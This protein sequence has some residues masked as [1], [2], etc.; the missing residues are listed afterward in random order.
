MRG[1]SVISFLVVV[2]AIAWLILR[3]DVPGVAGAEPD[4]DL[5]VAEAAAGEIRDLEEVVADALDNARRTRR[6][7]DELSAAAE[8]AERAATEIGALSVDNEAAGVTQVAARL[9]AED[10]E[11]AAL[12][13][14]RYADT[15]L[16]RMDAAAEAAEDAEAIA[17]VAIEVEETR[18]AAREAAAAAHAAQAGLAGRAPDGAL[19]GEVAGD[20]YDGEIVI[21]DGR[22]DQGADD[23]RQRLDAIFPDDV[24]DEEDVPYGERG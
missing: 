22:E 21:I 14:R 7:A 20:G 23:V 18:N 15:L 11:E 12:L 24:L 16:A 1:F 10:A 5:G 4:T 3:A 19:G 6:L 2:G 9:A 8:A 17:D 13:M